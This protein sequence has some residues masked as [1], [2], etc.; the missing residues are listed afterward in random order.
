[1]TGVRK[2]VRRK[3]VSKTV[4]VIAVEVT[5]VLSEYTTVNGNV[6]EGE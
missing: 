3:E 6:D 5:R 2:T 1:M 4:T